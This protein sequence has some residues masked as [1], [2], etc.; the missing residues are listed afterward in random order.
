MRESGERA[1]PKELT[2]L[3]H[4]EFTGMDRIVRITG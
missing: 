4:E 2:E 3:R 1:K